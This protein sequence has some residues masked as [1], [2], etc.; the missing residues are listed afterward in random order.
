MFKTNA[1][2]KMLFS[3]KNAKENVRMMMEEK[4]EFHVFK[5]TM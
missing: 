1:N 2:Q 4:I 3:V 5:T